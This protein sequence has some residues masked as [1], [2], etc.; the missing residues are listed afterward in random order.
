MGRQFVDISMHLENDVISDPPG[1]EPRIE[2]LTHKDTASDVTAFFP[3]LEE[4][5]LPDGEGWAIEWIR[6]MTHNGTHLD[7]PYHFHSTMDRGDRAITIDEVPLDWCFNPGVKLDFRAFE[8]GYVVQPEDVEAE[9]GRIGHELQPMEIVVINTAAG[10][11]YGTDHYVAAGCGMGREATLYL[12]ERGVRVTGT[13]AWSW[14]APFVHTKDKYAETGNADLIW[15][16]HKA[17]REI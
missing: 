15:E 7:A 8:A 12:L 1:Y 14:D 2:Y 4:E 13:D 5:D 10:D 3:G 6:L 11:A 16:G 17:G 9:L